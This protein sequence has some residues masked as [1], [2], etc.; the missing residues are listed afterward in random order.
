MR[1]LFTGLLF[2]GLALAGCKPAAPI[3][4]V[5][6]PTSSARHA[7]Y[8]GVGLYGAD[9]GWEHVAGAPK[10]ANKAVATTADDTTVIV[11]VD[12]AT[13][14]IRQCGNYSG[15]CIAMNPWRAKLAPRQTEPV[16][17]NARQD[18]TGNSVAVEGFDDNG[19]SPADEPVKR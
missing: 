17:L 7:R 5:E 11:T 6:N 19:T 1:G 15:H 12:G 8:A 10:P 4:D 14:E 16:S 13:G 18:A 2:A 9:H 3:D